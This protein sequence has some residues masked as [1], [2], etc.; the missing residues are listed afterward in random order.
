MHPGVF[1]IV[2]VFWLIIVK[3]FHFW[4]SVQYSFQYLG[5]LGLYWLHV[6]RTATDSLDEFTEVTYIS[7]CEDCCVPSCTWVSC[8]N[9][10]PWFTAKLSQRRSQEEWDR[11]RCRESWHRFSKVVR[12]AKWL[13]QFSANNPG[14]VCHITSQSTNLN[15]NPIAW[16]VIICFS[17]HYTGNTGQ[18]VTTVHCNNIFIKVKISLSYLKT[19]LMRCPLNF[20]VYWAPKFSWATSYNFILNVI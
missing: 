8:N 1:I 18:T 11:D 20:T 19:C 17:Q 3:V 4:I 6:F 15:N 10:K 16:S 13:Y 5:L 12:E 14:S 2:F 9:D 7:C